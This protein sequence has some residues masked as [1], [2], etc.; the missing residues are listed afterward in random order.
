MTNP[1]VSVVITTRNEE[2]HI[3][4]CLESLKYQSYKDIEIIVVDNSSTDSTKSIAAQFTDNVFDKGPERS[5]QRNFGI[6][7]KSTGKYAMF[8]DADMILAPDL[9]ETLVREATSKPQVGAFYIDEIILGTS[10]YSKI[11][12]FENS[13]YSNTPVE[14]VR[15]FLRDHFVTL[16]GFDINFS[17]AE[18]WDF[19]KRIKLITNTDRIYSKSKLTKEKYTSWFGVFY[20]MLKS[21]G[22]DSTNHASVIYHNESEI[23]LTIYLRKKDYY[24]QSLN[25]YIAKW[26]KDDPDIRKQLGL[27]Y[28]YFVIF[29]ENGKWMRL[30]KNPLLTFGMYSLKFLL[31]IIYLTR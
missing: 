30:L 21:L 10:L 1:L 5:A 22:I 27:L 11:R 15:F 18:D 19:N 26:G 16:G 17:A 7:E 9:I 28:R 14:C 31:G 3:R 13:F 6:I 25:A 8:I 23:S 12:R 24:S 2:R 20:E 29:T 4:S